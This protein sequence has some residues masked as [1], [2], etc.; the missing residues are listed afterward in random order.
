[1]ENRFSSAGLGILPA[2]LTPT[3]ARKEVDRVA[4]R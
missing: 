2:D 1:M 3:K 4:D